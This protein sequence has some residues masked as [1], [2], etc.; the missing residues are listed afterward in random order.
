[1]DAV[2]KLSKPGMLW[3]EP[4]PKMGLGWPR[5]KVRRPS[6]RRAHSR[7]G[8]VMWGVILGLLETQPGQWRSR[9]AAEA[10]EVPPLGL[11]WAVLRKLIIM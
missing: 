4:L 7:T 11:S 5:R 10:R 3:A 6:T 2:G 1:M 9:E 8:R